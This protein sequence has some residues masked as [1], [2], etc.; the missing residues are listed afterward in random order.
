[1]TIAGQIGLIPSQL[2][3]P[4]PPTFAREAILSLQHVRRILEVL[5]S[6]QT[7]GGGW[8]GWPEGMICWYA[9]QG[10]LEAAKRIWA[11]CQEEVSVGRLLVKRH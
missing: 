8:E 2:A 4:S 11:A 5:Q 1:M 10:D 7:A 3:L 9:R 6:K